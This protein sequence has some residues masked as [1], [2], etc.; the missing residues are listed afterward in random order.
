MGLDGNKK[1]NGP[2][3]HLVA[4]TLCSIVSNIFH[5]ANMHDRKG[6][7]LLIRNLKKIYMA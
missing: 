6:A 1:T 2:K 3:R 7:D 4:D 5:P